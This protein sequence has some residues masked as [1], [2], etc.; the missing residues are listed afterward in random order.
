LDAGII[1]GA[2]V[3]FYVEFVQLIFHVQINRLSQELSPLRDSPE[4][5]R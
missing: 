2:A 4:K 3:V 5:H 1:S